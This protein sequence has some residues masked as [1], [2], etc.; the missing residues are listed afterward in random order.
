M[1]LSG[2]GSVTVRP[3]TL[4]APSGEGIVATGSECGRQTNQ[5]AAPCRWTLGNSARMFLLLAISALCVSPVLANPAHDMLIAKSNADRNLFFAKFL[6]S[7]GNDCGRVKRNFFQ[8]QDQAGDAFWNVACA[9]GQAYAI[10]VS[11]DAKGSTRIVPCDRL[12]ATNASK[13]FQQFSQ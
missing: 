12:R 4:R 7:S 6:K 9:N 2:N 5:S 11:N 3:A 1:T 13:C 10:M 8:G